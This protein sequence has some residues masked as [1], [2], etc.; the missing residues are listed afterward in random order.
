VKHT[1]TIAFTVGDNTEI[2]EHRI[3]LEATDAEQDT[4]RRSLT[5]LQIHEIVANDP[6]AGAKCFHALVKLVFTVALNA[7]IDPKNLRADGLACGTEPGVFNFLSAIASVVEPQMRRSLHLHAL[8]SALGFSSV[9]ELRARFTEDFDAV[10]RRLWMWITSLYWTS[11][12]GYAAFLHEDAALEILRTAPLVPFT[13]KQ[14]GMVGVEEVRKSREAQLEARGMLEPCL[15]GSLQ[16]TKFKPWQ[17][18]FYADHDLSSSEWATRASLDNLAGTRE[19]RQ[20]PHSHKTHVG[21][22]NTV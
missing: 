10:V 15:A 17:Q 1:F 11:P 5:P 8:L 12:E 22:Q 14:A 16:K 7:T 4:F 3:G 6:V 18:D 19:Q 20:H 21:N 9:E 2:F 13:E